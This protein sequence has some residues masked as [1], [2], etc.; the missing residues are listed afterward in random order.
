MSSWLP[1]LLLLSIEL[2]RGTPPSCAILF[3]GEGDECAEPFANVWLAAAQDEAVRVYHTLNGG[4][5]KGG[6]TFAAADPDRFIAPLDVP[7]DTLI[8]FDAKVAPTD[9]AFKKCKYEDHPELFEDDPC[10]EGEKAEKHKRAELDHSACRP[11]SSWLAIAIAKLT[12]ALDLAEAG[13]FDEAASYACVAEYLFSQLSLRID[14]LF[15][16]SKLTFLN[17]FARQNHRYRHVVGG[18]QTAMFEGELSVVVRAVQSLRSCGAEETPGVSSVLLYSAFEGGAEGEEVVPA[19][20]LLWA[21]TGTLGPF[22]TTLPASNLCAKNGEPTDQELVFDAARRFPE[23]TL[24]DR[25]AVLGDGRQRFYIDLRPLAGAP[26]VVLFE[27]LQT[28]KAAVSVAQLDLRVPFVERAELE[29]SIHPSLYLRL[30]DG[31]VCSDVEALIVPPPAEGDEAIVAALASANS[32]PLTLAPGASQCVGGSRAGQSCTQLTECG[33]GLACRRK[34]FGP[35]NIAFC[36]D[37]VA[38]DETRACAFADA[39]DQCPY[40]ECIGLVSGLEGGAFPFLYFYKSSNCGSDA[41]DAVT[42]GEPRVADW[43]A[44][45]NENLRTEL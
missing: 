28:A 31:D 40:G 1:V 21:V 2:V 18:S 26:N 43:H 41:R 7:V 5:V 22:G 32:V 23:L 16:D 42:C 11:F 10:K 33:A 38:W 30:A 29:T 20:Q 12:R 34:P 8:C 3:C 15:P 4:Q 36:Y 13:Q 37:G 17:A 45:P 35:R 25:V 6:C 44:Y 9:C 39:D 14:H 19:T 27:G 24:K